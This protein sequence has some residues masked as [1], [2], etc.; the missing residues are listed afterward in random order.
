M[1]HPGHQWGHLRTEVRV[2]EETERF[3]VPGIGKFECA[4]V[5]EDEYCDGVYQQQIRKWLCIDRTTGSMYTMGEVHWDIDQM[6]RKVFDGGWRVGEPDKNGMAEPGLL[7]PG[8]PFQGGYKYGFEGHDPEA[9]SYAENMEEGIA[10]ETPA[11]KFKDCVK[12]R[13]HSLT[14]P[15]DMTDKW[16]F[17]GVGLIKDTSQGVLVASDALPHTDM[18]SFG[19]RQREPQKPVAAPV[20]KITKAQATEIALKV[21][22][23]EARSIQIE[24]RGKRTVYAVEI[25]G[26]KDG[27]EWDVFVDIETGEVVGTDS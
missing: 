23:G 24:K 18:S 1:E 15:A 7:M 10:L 21:I 13:V 19:K 27:I 5:E 2:L 6:G 16:Y 17:K 22:P 20:A 9:Y 14:N 4:I 11:G 26:K 12:V 8:G 3:D 25:I